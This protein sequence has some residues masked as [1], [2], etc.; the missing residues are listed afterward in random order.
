MGGKVAASDPLKR[1]LNEYVR[2][3]ED[4]RLK[5]VKKVLSP[6]KDR[7]AVLVRGRSG[8]NNEIYKVFIVKPGGD[9]KE[10]KCRFVADQVEGIDLSWKGNSAIQVGFKGARVLM[11]EKERWGPVSLELTGSIKAGSKEG[12]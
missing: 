7:E 2:S 10:E 1:L 3:A 6:K 11:R 4:S 12:Y 8:R 9:F 5:V